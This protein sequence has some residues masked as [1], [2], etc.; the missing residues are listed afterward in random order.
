ML[1]MAWFTRKAE[2]IAKSK[3]ASMWL[4]NYVSV[5]GSEVYNVG[6]PK[7]KSREDKVVVSPASGV[8]KQSVMKPVCCH[9]WVETEGKISNSAKST[10]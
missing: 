10:N 9:R 8:Y 7:Y 6:W 2:R 4:H 3:L 1:V 5:V